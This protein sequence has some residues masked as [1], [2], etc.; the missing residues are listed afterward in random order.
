MCL[1]PG[2]CRPPAPA[3]RCPQLEEDIAAKEKLL[4]ASEDERDRVLEELHKAEDSLLAA[5]ETAAK[6][7]GRAAW[8]STRMANFLFLSPSLSFPV[9]LSL[10]LS[11]SFTVCAPS[12]RALRDHAACRTPH[13]P[14]SPC[15][16]PP[17]PS[18]KMSWCHCKRNS[19]ALKMNW[20]NTL[21]LSKMPRR[22]W[23]WLR[24]RPQM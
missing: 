9:S 14:P 19:R 12:P 4:R 15:T 22:S 1:T 23:S 6:V 16:P 5:D 3:C 10:P 18:W 2:P 7:P 11:L 20:T 8:H 21:R 17:T 13:P 24:K